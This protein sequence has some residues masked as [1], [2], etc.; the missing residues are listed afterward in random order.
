MLCIWHELTWIWVYTIMAQSLIT[1]NCASVLYYFIFFCLL[2]LK[3]VFFSKFI[4]HHYPPHHPT[5]ILKLSR[6]NFPT[7][8]AIFGN[9]TLKNWFFPFDYTRIRLFEIRLFEFRPIDFVW[10]FYFRHFDFRHFDF[11]QFDFD[12]LNGYR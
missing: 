5:T 4:Y 7:I 10:L 2:T 12:F 9:R 3:N 1:K 6:L 11:R 8:F